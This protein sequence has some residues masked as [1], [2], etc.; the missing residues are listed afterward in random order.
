MYEFANHRDV[1]DRQTT[2][3]ALELVDDASL[4]HH[5]TAVVNSTSQIGVQLQGGMDLSVTRQHA[6]CSL[7]SST[8]S[9]SSAPTAATSLSRHQLLVGANSDNTTQ[10]EPLEYSNGLRASQ[11]FRGVNN[12]CIFFVYFF[13]LNYITQVHVCMKSSTE[14][15]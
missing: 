11:P 6:H 1:E 9:S 4:L 10:Q 12:N 2:A 13:L 3:L 15:G 7:A 14:P 5:Q 8:S